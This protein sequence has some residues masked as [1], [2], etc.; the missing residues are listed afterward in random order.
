MTFYVLEQVETLQQ[1]DGSFVMLVCL[2]S[3]LSH[4]TN[5]RVLL[6]HLQRTLPFG[7]LAATFSAP[8][9]CGALTWGRGG[10]LYSSSLWA[11]SALYIT[12]VQAGGGWR[13]DS[14]RG[15]TPAASHHS[16]RLPPSSETT[17]QMLAAPRGQ[18]IRSQHSHIWIY[19]HRAPSHYRADLYDRKPPK[20][21]WLKRRW[22][23]RVS[24]S[25]YVVC[26]ANK[27]H[28]AIM[29]IVSSKLRV[30]KQRAIYGYIYFQKNALFYGLWVKNG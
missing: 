24:A 19:D 10:G 1:G 18:Q 14:P 20:W 30:R 28:A 13:L 2:V 15:I 23:L 6:S 27:W 3:L 4:D 26:G 29:T 16:K 8:D 9:R 22:Q 21:T 12:N 11:F 17:R 25:F 7:E 5:V